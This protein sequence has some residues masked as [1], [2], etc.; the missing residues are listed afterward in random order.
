MANRKCD[1][2]SSKIEAMPLFQRGEAFSPRDVYSY[3]HLK[4]NQV[5][6]ALG[7]MLDRGDV[8][9]LDDGKYVKPQRHWIHRTRLA[10]PVE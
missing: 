6:A 5:T 9:K 1:S 10:Q 4:P 8:R 7:A 3:L 2:V